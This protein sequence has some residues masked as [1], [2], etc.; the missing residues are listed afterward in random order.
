[1]KARADEDERSVNATG[2]VGGRRADPARAAG[3]R[4][5]VSRRS[6]AGRPA[7][8]WRARRVSRLGP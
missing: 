3:E 5:R 8:T 7:F 1:V 6:S 4:R 2:P